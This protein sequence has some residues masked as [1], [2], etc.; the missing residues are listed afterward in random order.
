GTGAGGR[1]PPPGRT[2]TQSRR[3]GSRT[4][5]P[6]KRCPVSSGPAAGTSPGTA[7]RGSPGPPRLPGRT[8][9][10]AAP[11]RSF[12]QPAEKGE[13][14]AVLRVGDGGHFAQG[15]QLPRGGVQ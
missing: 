12:E 2:G 8:P 14:R 3:T 5:H 4:A 7:K 15:Q 11:G 9:P 13:G 6:P 10:R 1:C